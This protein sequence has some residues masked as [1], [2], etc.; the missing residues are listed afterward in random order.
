MST[1]LFENPKVALGFAGVV[2]AVA[3]VASVAFKEFS[4]S[5]DASEPAVAAEQ[6]QAAQ[7]TPQ[8]AQ[9]SAA[10][11][12][13]DDSGVAGD[14]GAPSSGSQAGF[15]SGPIATNDAPV[16]GDHVSKTVSGRTSQGSNGP[17]ITTSVAP[18]APEVVP[19][20]RG[21]TPELKIQGG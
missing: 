19:P 21:S 14:W 9:S 10:T 13:A 5:E 3:L 7:A 18:G 15:A 20:S 4:P 17:K 12:W 2:V 6:A 8:Q 1:S 16:Y 11:G